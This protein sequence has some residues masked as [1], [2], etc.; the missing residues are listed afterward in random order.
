MLEIEISHL[1]L[2]WTTFYRYLNC[3]VFKNQHRWARHHSNHSNF[4]C[5]KADKGQLARKHKRTDADAFNFIVVFVDIVTSYKSK[6]KRK[7][8]GFM[9]MPFCYVQKLLAMNVECYH[10]VQNVLTVTMQ[11]PKIFK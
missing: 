3:N 6:G 7:V 1:T 10:L 8:A 2:K 9:A 11:E 5:L 4:K